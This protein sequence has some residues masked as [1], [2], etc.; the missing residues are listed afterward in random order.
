M[1]NEASTLDLLCQTPPEPD[2][3][4]VRTLAQVST[5]GENPYYH[6]LGSLTAPPSDQ[7]KE[8]VRILVFSSDL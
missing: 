5:G 3:R 2:V 4:A 7:A 8:T 1:K 6:H